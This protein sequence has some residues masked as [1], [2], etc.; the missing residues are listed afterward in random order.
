MT[1]PRGNS[2]QR[3]KVAPYS[4]IEHIPDEIQRQNAHGQVMAPHSS[5]PKPDSR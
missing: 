2:N 3:T 5:R 4:R 1:P